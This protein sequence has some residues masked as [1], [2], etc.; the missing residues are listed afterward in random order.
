MPLRLRGN[1]P[2]YA[3]SNMESGNDMGNFQN[4]EILS[5][6]SLLL[7]SDAAEHTFSEQIQFCESTTLAQASPFL[8]LIAGNSSCCLVL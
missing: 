1:Q 6:H 4:F 8:C 3:S 7:C 2:H 5:W